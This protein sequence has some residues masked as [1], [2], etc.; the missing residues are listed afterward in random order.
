MN[1]YFTFEF[2]FQS[3]QCV[4]GFKNVLRHKN[5]ILAVVVCVPRSDYAELS[6]FT[7][8]F[9]RRRQRNVQ[10]FITHVHS[11]LFGDILVAVVVVVCLKGQ[12]REDFAVLGQFCAK[13]IALRL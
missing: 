9:C 8:L 2:Q 11:L 7:L 10:R 4:N 5:E 1:L 13:I 12:C 3:V 6:H